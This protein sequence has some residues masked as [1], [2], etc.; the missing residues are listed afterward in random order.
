MDKLTAIGLMSGTSADGVDAALLVTDGVDVVEPGAALTI[1]YSPDTRARLLRAHGGAGPVAEIEE[2]ITRRHADAVATLLA[3]TGMVAG[4]IDLIGF[5]GHTI[6]HQPRARRSWQIG[7]AA[8]L[9]RLTGIGVCSDFRAADV[10]AGGQG[11]P[12]A[13]VFHAALARRLQRPIAILNLGGVANLSWLG[14]DCDPIAF[15]TGPANALID[16][17]VRAHTGA[18]FDDNGALA[19]AGQV[20]EPALAALLDNPYFDQA[21]PKSLDRDAFDATPVAALSLEDGC[22]TLTAFTAAT[23]RRALDHLPRTPAR[24]LATGGG[25]HNPTLMR[26]LADSLERPVAPVE[27]VGWNGDALEAQAFAYLAVRSRRGLALSYPSTTGVAAALTGGV[28]HS[29][30]ASLG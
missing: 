21:P 2:E 6:L 27:E 11:A 18:P 8:L 19:A 7:D 20:D 17:W 1:A 15:D 28:Y 30:P 25:R 22:A 5:H 14:Q 29:P 10:A 13:P 26:R 4:S 9:A 3:Q 16:D 12:L 23:V 24:V